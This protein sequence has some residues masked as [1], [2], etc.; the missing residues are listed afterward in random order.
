MFDLIR[1]S[2]F[3]PIQKLCFQFPIVHFNLEVR[4]WNLY[5]S[6][7]WQVFKKSFRHWKKYIVFNFCSLFQSR[8][9]M[10]IHTRWSTW[11][12]HSSEISENAFKF[13]MKFLVCNPPPKT[14]GQI[15]AKKQMKKHFLLARI[16]LQSLFANFWPIPL[17]SV[18]FEVASKLVLAA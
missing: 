9:Y 10:H 14:K 8:W 16:C 13:E 3:R 18:P 6:I 7:F 15:T 2:N 11:S 12:T 1:I 17:Q 5:Y 4:S